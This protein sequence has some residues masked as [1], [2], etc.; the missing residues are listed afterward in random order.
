E[1]QLQVGILVIYPHLDFHP[2]KIQR[3]W[4][5][6]R[7]LRSDCVA[8][9]KKG[10]RMHTNRITAFLEDFYIV[11]ESAEA[12]HRFKYNPYG[13]MSPTRTAF[14]QAQPVDYVWEYRCQGKRHDP[15]VNL[16]DYRIGYFHPALGRWMQCDH[17]GYVEG[18]N[19]YPAAD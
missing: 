16:N 12:A 3:G 13:E 1:N 4:E 7:L 6:I 9:F 17:V 10:H 14:E 15:A 5:S 2:L 11:N 18:V 8:R 19:H